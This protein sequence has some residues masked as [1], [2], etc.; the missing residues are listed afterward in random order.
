[1]SFTPDCTYCPMDKTREYIIK[2]WHHCA[3]NFE[4]NDPRG[5]KNGILPPDMTAPMCS[6]CVG[7]FTYVFRDYSSMIATELNEKRKKTK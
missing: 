4:E 1:M 2:M 3:K 6:N 7:Y 5:I